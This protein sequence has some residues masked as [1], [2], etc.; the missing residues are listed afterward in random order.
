MRIALF[1]LTLALAGCAASIPAVEVTRFHTG[2]AITPGGFMPVRTDGGD[3]RSPEFQSYVVAVTHELERL[4]YREPPTGA[5]YLVEIE[6]TRGTRTD[7]NR[8]PPVQIGV[9]GGTFGGN[10]GIGVGTTFGV[11]NG[12]RETVITQ[13]SV[14]IKSRTDGKPL[15]EGRAQTQSSARA[16]AAQPGLAASK[17]ASALFQGFPG[18]SGETITVQ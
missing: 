4:G 14:R 1:A 6:Y 15:W 16:P 9:G 18:K 8:R 2:Q 7:F 13:L 10:V 11:G 17:L 5:T 12:T 3:P